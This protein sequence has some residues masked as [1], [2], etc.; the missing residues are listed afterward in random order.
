ML[1]CDKDPVKLNTKHQ[2]VF[3]EN[4]SSGY[5]MCKA[6]GFPVPQLA[7]RKEN[8]DSNLDNVAMDLNSLKL[9]F[10]ELNRYVNGTYICIVTTNSSLFSR[11]DV[12]IKCN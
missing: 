12:I 5:I 10:N 4:N 8:N 7:W 9:T 6:D 3:N 1:L 2:V 11:T